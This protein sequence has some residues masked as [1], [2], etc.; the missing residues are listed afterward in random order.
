MHNSKI[1]VYLAVGVV[2]LAG[3]GISTLSP[4]KHEFEPNTPE[5]SQDNQQVLLGTE[6]TEEESP[7]PVICLETEDL[8]KQT[9]EQVTEVEEVTESSFVEIEVTESQEEP[10]H[11]V[12]EYHTVS[13][14]MMSEDLQR[15]VLWYTSDKN[16]N[17]YLIIAMCEKESCCK[18]DV[19]GDNG[20]SYGIMQVQPRW[21]EQRLKEY[22]LT[23]DDLLQ[24]QNCIMLGID[25]LLEYKNKGYST[26]YMLMCYNGGESYAAK[27]TQVSEYAIWVM[28]RAQYLQSLGDY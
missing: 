18:Y 16:I 27:Q 23:A 7:S 22:G 4:R 2:F 5:I 21:Q 17:P 9:F 28:N 10:E 19:I 15:W 14:S 6:G 1:P 26:E 24:P 20:N 8:V 13:E 11:Y 3:L 12:P 25:I